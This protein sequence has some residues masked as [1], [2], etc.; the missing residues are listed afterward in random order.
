MVT[1]EYTVTVKHGG[2]YVHDEDV[3]SRSPKWAARQYFSDDHTRRAKD[4]Y[5]EVSRYVSVYNTSERQSPTKFFRW[6]PGGETICT[7]TGMKSKSEVR[8]IGATE[9]YRNPN[10]HTNQEGA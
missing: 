8:E 2:T 5:L 3:W 10:R 1:R 9:F 6:F 4:H 7:I